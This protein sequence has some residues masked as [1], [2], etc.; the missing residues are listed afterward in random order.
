MDG[1]AGVTLPN[2]TGSFVTNGVTYPYTMLGTDP[3]LGSATT[4]I[5]V[6]LIPLRVVFSDGTVVSANAPVSG[7]SRSA[8]KLTQASPMFG[9]APFSPGGTDVGTTQYIDAFQR[10]NFWNFVSTTAPD[11]HLKF[12]VQTLEPVQTINVPAYFGYAAFGGPGKP[13]GYVN[14]QWWDGQLGL[15]LYSGLIH[16]MGGVL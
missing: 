14:F 12:Y 11:Y 9:P 10:A 2:W 16:R 7:D 1:L 3:S 15:L 5:K 6:V 8:T 13:I 4:W